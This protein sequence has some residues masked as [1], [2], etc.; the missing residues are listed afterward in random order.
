MS[1]YVVFKL[2]GALLVLRRWRSPR[3]NFHLD[4]L[5]FPVWYCY[6]ISI[7]FY[8]IWYW[9]SSWYSGYLW[10]FIRL[11]IRKSK[12]SNPEAIV[13]KDYHFVMGVSLSV[14]VRPAF[15]LRSMFGSL[16]NN[17]STVYAFSHGSFE[18]MFV[19][20]HLHVFRATA[21]GE[22]Y[23]G[24]SILVSRY[25]LQRKSLKRNIGITLHEKYEKKNNRKW[26]KKK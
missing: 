23:V 15:A 19:E 20:H 22:W 18:N 1:S 8:D 16:N 12:A 14:C 4:S 6:L 17:N 9:L 7:Y 24:K 13:E 10:L 21:F 25:G 26:K 5:I 2:F 3:L 11:F